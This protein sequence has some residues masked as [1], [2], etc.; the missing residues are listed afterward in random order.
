MGSEK[1]D[2]TW[3][4]ICALEGREFRTVTGLPFTYAILGVREAKQ[5]Q[6]AYWP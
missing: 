3:N 5:S 6:T 2:D 4:R 1:L